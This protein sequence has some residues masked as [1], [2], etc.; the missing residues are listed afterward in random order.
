MLQ[1]KKIFSLENKRY[2][3]VFKGYTFLIS[4][5][6]HT[7]LHLLKKNTIVTT[8]FSHLFAHPAMGHLKILNTLPTFQA[9]FEFVLLWNFKDLKQSAFPDS[10]TFSN[11]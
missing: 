9:Y 11:F 5:C 8:A 3:C 6:L 1:E 10:I 4:H 2:F 7:L